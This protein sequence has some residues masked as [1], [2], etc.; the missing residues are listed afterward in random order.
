VSFPGIERKL[1]AI[2]YADV[3]GATGIAMCQMEGAIV[4][5]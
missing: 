2:L 3:T 5:R 4:K 1:T